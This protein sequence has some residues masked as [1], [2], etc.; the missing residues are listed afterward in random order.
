[1][2]HDPRR[3]VLEILSPLADGRLPLD[4]LIEKAAPRIE[5]LEGK[6]EKLFYAILMGV[7]R[8]RSQLDWALAQ[9]ARKPLNKLSPAVLE[10]LRM[11]AFQILH[12]ERVPNFAAVNTTVDLA[13]RSRHAWAGGL[14]NGILRKLAAQPAAIRWPDRSQSPLQHLAVTTAMPEWLVDR[15][16]RQLG[17]AI[18]TK[19]C[20]ATLQIPPMT[21][22]CNPLK[23]DRAQ[24]LEDLAAHVKNI[25]K[26]QIS[27][28]G[29]RVQGLK[30]RLTSLPPFTRGLFQV[31]DEA[32]QLV[33]GLCEPMPGQRILDACA[34]LGTKTG[35][36]ASLAGPTSDVVALDKDAAKIQRLISEMKRLGLS[37]VQAHAESLGNYATRPV[38]I[39]FDCV[40]VDA[41]CCGWGVLRR[42]P[43]A[44]WRATA[45]QVGRK[46]KIQMQLL[47]QAAPLV[48]PT[49][50]LVYSVCTTEPEETDAVVDAFLATHPQFEI[51]PPSPLNSCIQWPP[52]LI[53][54]QGYLKILMGQGEMD[55]FFAVRLRRR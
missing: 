28:W 10:L 7:L 34:G 42:N 12:L 14:I 38:S 1:M 25:Q 46:A 37:Q 26:T 51:D 6:D 13:K 41:P 47:V 22:R 4:Q 30:T 17:L 32:A 45:Q 43:D 19:I 20:E 49:G 29:L 48:K 54:P 8:R 11:G 31:Q 55:G 24:L 36:L 3:L 27:P 53:T 15:W 2:R 40:L 18:T 23:A 39:P 33:G 35:H 52:N 5:S 21:L 50:L 9:Y 44:K 16:V